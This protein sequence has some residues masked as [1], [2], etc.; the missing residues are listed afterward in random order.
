MENMEA[1][2]QQ[3]LNEAIRPL[4]DRITELTTELERE[5]SVNAPTI[6]TSTAPA[7]P[8]VIPD[9]TVPRRKPLPD[10]PKFSGKRREYPAW[11]QQMRDKLTI[12][13]YFLPT[14]EER[15]YYINSR[16]DTDPQQVVAT[17][18]AAGGDD[19]TKNPDYFLK[20]LDR[21]YREAKPEAQAIAQLKTLRQ[22]DNERLATF[23]PRFERTLAD[24]GGYA[25]PDA[26][27]ITMLEGALNR[28][29]TDLLITVDLPEDYGHWISRWPAADPPRRPL[30]PETMTGTSR[31]PELCGRRIEGPRPNLAAA[32]PPPPTPRW[33][34]ANAS[35]VDKRDILLGTVVRRAVP[36]G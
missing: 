3:M 11:A 22:R 27:K 30:P 14:N 15:W 13:S 19:G 28:E 31:C 18:Y 4:Q 35:I 16:L 33:T 12:D 1:Q 9:N 2:F 29:L 5:R 21:T 23:L 20:Y 26:V 25:W 32:A 6:N 36:R 10:P 17:F 24:A 34:A 7:T 8:P